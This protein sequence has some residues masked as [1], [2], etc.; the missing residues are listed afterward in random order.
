MQVNEEEQPD[1]ER[2]GTFETD[3]WLRG[4]LGKASVLRPTG[5]WGRD[6]LSSWR[7]A[8]RWRRVGERMSPSPVRHSRVAPHRS[9]R[10]PSRSA[11]LSPSACPGLTQTDA[12]LCELA[13]PVGARRTPATHQFAPGGAGARL[14]QGVDVSTDGDL[15][16]QSLLGVLG[17]PLRVHHQ[18]PV[19]GQA[20]HQAVRRPPFGGALL[21]D[22]QQHI[23]GSQG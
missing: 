19:G 8:S 1:G 10:E 9:T 14:P 21:R 11:L 13:A 3:L 2:R 20:V 18:H 17:E 4:R 5:H 22:T 15:P 6:A 12:L 23:G 7:S 16:P